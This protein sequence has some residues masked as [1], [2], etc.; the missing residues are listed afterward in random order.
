[1]APCLL[2]ND[3]VELSWQQLCK[4]YVIIGDMAQRAFPGWKSF[5]FRSNFMYSQLGIGVRVM[6]YVL[7]CTLL[8]R[9]SP[10]RQCMD[11]ALHRLPRYALWDNDADVDALMRNYPL[12]T[13]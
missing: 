11:T 6:A 3:V 12:K 7:T 1:M 5:Y 4:L 10:T 13:C 9:P 8:S 2:V